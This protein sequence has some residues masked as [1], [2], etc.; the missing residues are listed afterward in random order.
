MKVIELWPLDSVGDKTRRQI[1][2]LSKW[3]NGVAVTCTSLILLCTILLV[4]ADDR[5]N[6]L[7]FIRSIFDELFTTWNKILFVIFKMTISLVS[8]QLS[9]P[10]YQAIYSARHLTFQMKLCKLFI[11]SLSSISG[12]AEDNLIYDECY[13]E[14]IEA[15]LYVIIR[16][17]CDFL[18]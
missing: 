15:R 12:D 3:I 2:S 10:T 4:F 8:F 13:Q 1:A 17:H 16:R 9:A 5:D 6:G 18:A 11:T 14:E 7:A